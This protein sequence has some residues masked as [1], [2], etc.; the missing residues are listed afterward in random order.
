MNEQDIIKEM[1]PEVFAQRK[2]VIN[3]IPDIKPNNTINLLRTL[4]FADIE[5][6]I[7]TEHTFAEKREPIFELLPG[8]AE[9]S[10]LSH[11]NGMS[12]RIVITTIGA[13]LLI[14][15]FKSGLVEQKKKSSSKDLSRLIAYANSLPELK[16]KS[17]QLKKT[18]EEKR[19][20][21]LSSNIECAER[22]EHLLIHPENGR[23]DELTRE[24]LNKYAY[25]I[26]PGSQTFKF[27]GA[28]VTKRVHTLRSNSGKTSSTYVSINWTLPDGSVHGDTNIEPV[29]NRRN[30]PSR[31]WGLGR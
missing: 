8:E 13:K 5:N 25:A 24:F 12:D 31:N 9:L 3:L 15:L 6:E 14:R 30:D 28:N 19:A 10:E 27:A 21:D 23:P 1:L 26:G 17:D 11:P 18:K 2:E 29:L 22:I 20:R 4:L 16:A 7:F